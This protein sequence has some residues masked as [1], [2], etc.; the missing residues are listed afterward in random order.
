M[1]NTNIALFDLD[2][3]LLAGDSDQL[4]GEF[5]IEQGIVDHAL[6]QR[7]ND[8]FYQEYKQGTLDIH[9]FLAFSLKPLAEHDM[10]TLQAWRRD[11]M[12]QKIRPI[13]LD[14]G[15]ALLE[16]HRAQGHKLV[17]ITATNQFVTA[18]IAE[19]FNVDALLATEPEIKDGRYTGQVIDPPCFQGGKV[20]RLKQWLTQQG[21]NL[22]SSWFYS[23]SHNDLPLL[24]LSTHA[25]AVDP[26]ET[27][28][29]HAE[30]KGWPIMSLRN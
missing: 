13:M 1:P 7:E 4:W 29:Q 23:D 17:I 11:F 30:M 22:T 10:A 27:L 12:E 26:D 28:Q 21:L 3:T 8:R 20:T 9:E 2:N 16:K 5:L 18:P 25:I 24:E 19:A 14:Q 15:Y 6:Y